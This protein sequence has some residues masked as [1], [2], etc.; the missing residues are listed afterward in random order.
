MIFILFWWYHLIFL[1]VQVTFVLF[2]W[3]K[4]CPDDST[5]GEYNGLTLYEQMDAGVPWTITKKFLMLVP[6]ILYVYCISS[7]FYCLLIDM[8]LP[9][10][11]M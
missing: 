1:C 2:H 10:F 3:V 8:G 5:Q 11:C 6:T 7:S 9:L 4:G